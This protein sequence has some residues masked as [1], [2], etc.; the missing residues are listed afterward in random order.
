M[1]I[2]P[3]GPVRIKFGTKSLIMKRTLSTLILAASFSFAA[4]AQTKALQTAKVSLPTIQ[5]EMAK[6]QIEQYLKRIDGITFANVAFKKK[7]VTVKFLTDRTNLE[8]IKA[9]IANVGY[10]AAEISANPDSYKALPKCC[11]KPD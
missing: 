10:D 8:T 7:E 11:K 6:A 4:T 9:S 3:L 2:L 5:C 1:L